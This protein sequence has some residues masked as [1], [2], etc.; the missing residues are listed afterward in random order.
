MRRVEDKIG[1]TGR[2]PNVRISPFP[3][4]SGRVDNENAN[5][6]KKETKTRHARVRIW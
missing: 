5:R 2:R 4:E 3:D 6:D 1:P